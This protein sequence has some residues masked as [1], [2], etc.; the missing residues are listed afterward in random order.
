MIGHYPLT[1]YHIQKSIHI[2]I[3]SRTEKFKK[4]ISKFN[5]NRNSPPQVCSAPSQSWLRG[6]NGIRL[7]ACGLGGW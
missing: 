6:R 4:R 7:T 3:N 1:S 2:T 5:C